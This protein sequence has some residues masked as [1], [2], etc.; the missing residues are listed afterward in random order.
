MFFKIIIMQ[1]NNLII[2]KF[3][4]NDIVYKYLYLK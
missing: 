4:I 1:F 3:I 2:Y